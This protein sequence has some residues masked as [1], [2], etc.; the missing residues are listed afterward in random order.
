VG[1][2]QKEIALEISSIQIM[3]NMKE[4]GKM[5]K[6]IA[7][8]NFIFIWWTENTQKMALEMISIQMEG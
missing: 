2:W 4:S 3:N 1:K 5:T 7:L 6:E 8:E